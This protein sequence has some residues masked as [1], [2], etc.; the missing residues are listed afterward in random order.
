MLERD[1]IVKIEFETAVG[2]TNGR[3]DFQPRMM[4]VGGEFEIQSPVKLERAHADRDD[5]RPRARFA[6]TLRR[7]ISGPDP[8]VE[9]TMENTQRPIPLYGPYQL[10]Y[11]CRPGDDVD[12][13]VADIVEAEMAP[14]PAVP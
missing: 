9:I 1:K 13:S 3:T 7:K 2:V 6:V 10:Q 4:T 8:R 11:T 5:S 14:V 12:F